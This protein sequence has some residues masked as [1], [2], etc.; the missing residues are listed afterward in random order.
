VAWKFPD[1]AA[2]L[3]A[4]VRDCALA[5]R[6]DHHRDLQPGWGRLEVRLTTHSAGALTA[7]D[8][9]LAEAVHTARQRPDG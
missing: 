2:A 3:D 5:E 8:G 7:R 1:F 9:E 4:A 6:A